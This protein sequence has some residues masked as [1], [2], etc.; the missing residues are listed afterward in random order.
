MSKGRDL[1]ITLSD[2]EF[3]ALEDAVDQTVDRWIAE[4]VRRTEVNDLRT[5]FNKLADARRDQWLPSR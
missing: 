1:N 2:D 3:Y 4:D 5:A